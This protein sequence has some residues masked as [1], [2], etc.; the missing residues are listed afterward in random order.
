MD[1]PWVSVPAQPQCL[2]LGSTWSRKAEVAGIKGL[3]SEER[4]QSESHL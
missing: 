1:W 4:P 2:V 3:Q